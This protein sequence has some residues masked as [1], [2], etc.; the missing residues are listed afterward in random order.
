MI[1][2]IPMIIW[3]KKMNRQK[4][5]KI[6]YSR[7]IAY[8]SHNLFCKLNETELSEDDLLICKSYRKRIILFV[9]QFMVSFIL[10]FSYPFICYF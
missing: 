2:Q 9:G 1:I 3:V 4:D 8:R 6:K 7:D 10:L 5:F